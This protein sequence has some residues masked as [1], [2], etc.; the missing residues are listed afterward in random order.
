M[1]EATLQQVLA[2]FRQAKEMEEAGVEYLT[3][4]ALIDA[5]KKLEPYPEALRPEQHLIT[6]CTSTVTWRGSAAR[7]PWSMSPIPTPLSPGASWPSSWRSSTEDARAH[8]RRQDEATLH[9]SFRSTPRLSV[10]QYESPPGILRHAR[11]DSG[12]R[13]GPALTGSGHR[14]P[15]SHHAPTLTLRS[16]SGLS[17]SI[18][19]GCHGASAHARPAAR[20]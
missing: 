15:R 16:L 2:R 1:T 5:G 17:Q 20:P 3:F 6:K 18:L 9:R 19:M 4:N 12:D 14:R 10:D 11:P 8:R 7:A 13:A